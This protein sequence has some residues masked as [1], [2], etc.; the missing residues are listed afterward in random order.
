MVLEEPGQQTGHG[1]CETA[2]ESTAVISAAAGLLELDNGDTSGCILIN[3]VFIR[4][5]R[6]DILDFLDGIGDGGFIGDEE[7]T[8]FIRVSGSLQVRIIAEDGKAAACGE[9]GVNRAGQSL[10][11]N[12]FVSGGIRGAALPCDG[13]RHVA[14]D[15]GMTGK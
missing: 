7:Q 4:K 11:E 1:R 13:G 15:V 6:A 3:F 12:F 5:I 9:A 8:G 14:E 10:G 2:E